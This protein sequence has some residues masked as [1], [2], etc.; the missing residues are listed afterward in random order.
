MADPFG[1]ISP[2]IASDLARLRTFTPQQIRSTVERD[3][4]EIA[5]YLAKKSPRIIQPIAKSCGVGLRS[6]GLYEEAV[7]VEGAGEA[8]I[9]CISQQGARQAA[10][11]A[12]NAQLSA[13][14]EAILGVAASPAGGAAVLLLVIAVGLFLLNSGGT[15][16]SPVVAEAK[17]ANDDLDRARGK[18]RPPMRILGAIG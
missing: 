11:L 10:L 9:V 16:N 17:K 7:T 1:F 8:L 14:W 2:E 13:G 6:I 5:K 18:C 15:P 3:S 12:V 4:I